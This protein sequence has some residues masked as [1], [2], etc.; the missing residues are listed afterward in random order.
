VREVIPAH[1][2]GF[3]APPRLAVLGTVRRDGSAHLVPVKCMRVGEDFLVLTRPETLKVRNL[4]GHPRASLAEHTDTVWATV[5]GPARVDDDPALV[6]AAQAAYLER[7]GRHNSWGTTV[8]V[9]RP[10]RVLSGD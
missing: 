10:D 6:V 2:A 4:A 9:L 5:E 7:F 8:I 1:L 3:W